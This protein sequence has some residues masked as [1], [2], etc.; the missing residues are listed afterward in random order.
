MF[1]HYALSYAL[2]CAPLHNYRLREAGRPPTQGRGGTAE[3]ENPGAGGGGHGG[4]PWRA[5]SPRAFLPAFGTQRVLHSCIGGSGFCALLLRFVRAVPTPRPH[6]TEDG[7]GGFQFSASSPHA[8]ALTLYGCADRVICPADFARPDQAHV[9][10]APVRTSRSR[11][12]LRLHARVPP[13]HIVACP[14]ATPA[15][16]PWRTGGAGPAAARGSPDD[17]AELAWLPAAGRPGVPPPLPRGSA[18]G[19]GTDSGDAARLRR[20]RRPSGARPKKSACASTLPTADLFVFSACWL[21][22]RVPA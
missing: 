3:K 13:S 7:L 16:H 11:P 9:V 15:S 17:A 6:P 22:T 14:A 12:T 1:Q 20:V 21:A 2:T 19:R 18:G 4:G 10:G 8:S 5:L